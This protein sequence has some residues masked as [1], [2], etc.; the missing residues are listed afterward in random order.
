VA[1]NRRALDLSMRLYT[2]GQTDFLSV[3]ESQRALFLTEDALASSTGTVLTD[4]VG[5]YK[6]LGGGWGEPPGDAVASGLD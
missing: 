6:A 3:L 5:L 4:L 1:N 2:Q